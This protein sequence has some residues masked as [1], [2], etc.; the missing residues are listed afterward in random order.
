VHLEL[1]SAQADAEAMLAWRDIMVSGYS[2]AGQER[3]LAGRGIELLRGHGRLAGTGVVDVDDARYTA[4]GWRSSEADHDVYEGRHRKL[5]RMSAR[6][7][8]GSMYRPTGA[9]VA[10]PTTS[11]PGD[12][13]RR[14]QLGLRYSWIRDASFT[15]EALYIGACSDEAGEFLSFMTSSAGGADSL[16]IMYGIVGEHDLSER[17]PHTFA[18]G[19]ATP[20]RVGDGAWSQTK[21]AV[22]GE[23]LNTLY[24]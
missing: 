13:R 11:L 22:Y 9:I 10:A 21:L 12:R 1:A 14:A 6:V 23:L 19:E 2:D 16:Q 8:K 7:L 17:S 4:E 24:L 5:V 15:L 3:W 20:V 18:D